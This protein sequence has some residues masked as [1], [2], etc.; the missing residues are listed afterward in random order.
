MR[1]SEVVDL[2]LRCGVAHKVLSL[3]LLHGVGLGHTPVVASSEVVSA[4][5]LLSVCEI[6]EHCFR[7]L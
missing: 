1:G 5:G 2:A 7:V 6:A 4:Q 3:H